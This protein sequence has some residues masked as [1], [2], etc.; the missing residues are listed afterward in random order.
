MI[1][2]ILGEVL[3]NSNLKNAFENNNGYI[4]TDLNLSNKIKDVLLQKQKAYIN[5]FESLRNNDANLE[6]GVNQNVNNNF[7][8]GPEDDYAVDIRYLS[9]VE[10]F[11]NVL[12]KKY[13]VDLDTT[14]YTMYN[15]DNTG[16]CSY[17]NAC[18]SIFLSFRENP[19]LFKQTF[20]YDMYI[21][22]DGKKVL[23]SKAL[24]TD[25]YIFANSK[26][27]GG[28][29]FDINP[30]TGKLTVISPDNSMKNQ[31]YV[32]NST[33]GYNKNLIY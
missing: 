2:I 13:N 24:I 11:G 26:T 5:Y 22:I 14:L 9:A 15:L 21:E 10:D 17:A 7:M 28:K 20:G 23:N 25:L 29:I 4:G 32:S 8:R 30:E 12:E 16:A 3:S 1:G 27:N 31:V 6:F 33:S 18:N 19:E